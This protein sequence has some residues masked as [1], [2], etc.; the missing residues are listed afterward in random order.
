MADNESGAK[1][2]RARSVAAVSVA[3]AAA[4]PLIPAPGCV[5]PGI[6]NLQRSPPV[7]CVASARYLVSRLHGQ[8]DDLPV[9]G[10]TSDKG[11]ST[12]SIT[13]VNTPGLPPAV[14]TLHA[15]EESDSMSATAIVR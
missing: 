12:S 5:M 6:T 3:V 7:S 9:S 11:G 13:L 2:Y 8:P 15:T 4:V 10:D 1:S 14:A